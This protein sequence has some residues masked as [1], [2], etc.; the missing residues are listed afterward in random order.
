MK[1]PFRLPG[2]AADEQGKVQSG[3]ESGQPP[4]QARH[5]NP[6]HLTPSAPQE[7]PPVALP[8]FFLMSHLEDD[9]P[10]R[11]DGV[12]VGVC[13]VMGAELDDPKLG[14]FAGALNALDFPLQLLVRQHPPG[15]SGMRAGLAEAQ[16]ENLPER[17]RQAAGVPPSAAEGSGVARRH[18]R[19]AF[20]RGVRG[21]PARR[22][23]RPAGS[24]GVVRSLRS[25]TKTAS[26]A[27]ARVNSG[28]IAEGDR[29]GA[30]GGDR[31]GP[32]GHAHRGP[33]C[34]LVAPVAAGRARSRRVSCR[35]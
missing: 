16:P 25:G 15:L 12:K 10:V 31:G 7:K 26:D 6:D 30:R 28:R 22:S 33:P 23:A 27:A 21:E 35:G 9:G 34:P 14:A 17:T 11:I 32:A 2:A 24:G 5:P 20:L 19:P 13:E 29:R 8:L 18:S 4:S 3:H 1:I